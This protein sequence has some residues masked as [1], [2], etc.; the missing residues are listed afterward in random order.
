MVG[1]DVRELKTPANV[2]SQS[3]LS[4]HTDEAIHSELLTSAVCCARALKLETL[5]L[6]D[7][8]NASSKDRQLA[9]KSM[10]YLISVEAPHSLRRGI[11]P[12]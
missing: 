6:M 4:E 8:E 11:S 7:G 5:D 3:T 9:R 10:W 2:S 12:V 1:R